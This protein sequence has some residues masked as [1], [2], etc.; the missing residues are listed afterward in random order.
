VQRRTPVAL[1]AW[2]LALLAGLS[3]AEAGQR[4]RPAYVKVAEYQARGAIHLHGFHVPSTGASGSA[5]GAR[6]ASSTH[7]SSTGFCE[8]R[9]TPLSS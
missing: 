8:S 6:P 1:F 7:S 5:R 2:A 9:A 3:A 4:V